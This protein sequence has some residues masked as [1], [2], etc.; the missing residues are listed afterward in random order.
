MQDLPDPPMVQSPIIMPEPRPPIQAPP[1]EPDTLVA[2]AAAAARGDRRAFEA[3]HRRLSPGLQ[4]LFMERVNRRSELADDLSQRTW[5][6]TWEALQKG[7]YDPAKSAITTFVYAVGY[8][9]YLQHLRSAG[10]SEVLAPDAFERAGA[11]SD[12]PASVG[13]AAELIDAV[14]TCLKDHDDNPVLTEEERGLVRASASG[15]SDRDLAKQLRIAASTLN[16]RKQAAFE[17]IRRFLAQR[18]HRPSSPERP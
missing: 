13:A 7:R 2:L 3:I 8:K 17:K 18:G 11:S 4:R 15:A 5:L 14:R 1:R 6:A 10:R 16:A 9:L 12:D